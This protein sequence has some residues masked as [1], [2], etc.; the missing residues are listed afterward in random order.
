MINIKSSIY[1]LIISTIT[2]L[3]VFFSMILLKY[4]LMLIGGLISGFQGS[5]S[6]NNLLISV[7]NEQWTKAEVLWVYLMPYAGYL[8]IYILLS[9]SRK[10]PIK[11][12]LSFQF[13][14]S[15]AY[16]MLIIFVFVMP[17]LEIINK[18]GIYFPLIWMQTNYIIQVVF[19][20][21]LMIFFLYRSVN[22]SQ[23]FSTTL[24]LKNPNKPS[25]KEIFNQLIFMWFSPMI[26][27]AAIVL[28]LVS[29]N[30]AQ[31]LVFIF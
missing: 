6:L 29:F 5:F 3:V 12:S 4:L 2:L 8:L 24:S 10:F 13:L 11:L 25:K 15:W 9:H 17:L 14:Q 23:L 19:G 16:V 7:A 1:R 21:V 31:S 18:S 22:V 28:Y 27:L 26:L 30:P 20:I